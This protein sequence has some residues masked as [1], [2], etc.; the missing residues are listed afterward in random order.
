MCQ[1]YTARKANMSMFSRND[2]STLNAP[3]EQYRKLISKILHEGETLVN[4]R[5]GV[6]VF[7]HV[8]IP[9]VFT[10]DLG[11]GFPVFQNRKYSPYI[12][13]AETAWQ[14]SGVQNLDLINKY[15]PK[16]W[17][18]FADEDNLI[19][20]AQGYKWRY[21]FLRNQIELLIEQLKY[22]PTNRQLIVASWDPHIDGLG[23]TKPY[24]DCLPFMQ[25]LPSKTK[26]NLSVYS[27]SADMILGFPYDVF[28]YTFILYAVCNQA[29][30]TPGNL[31]IILNN[32]H[33][34][35]LPDHMEVAE[36]L[37]YRHNI[38][39]SILFVYPMYDV[40]D[41][42]RI[43]HEYILWVKKHMSI[44]HTYA[45]KVELVK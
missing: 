44:S 31:S 41:I 34:Y 36:N 9:Q 26:L 6:K 27:R 13:A 45:P 7:Q 3:T 40:R 5:T 32:M 12:S 43:P 38:E 33:V 29:G 20:N 21:G 42:M 35:D 8:T 17:S 18:K 2:M 15:A 23:S 11:S 19:R 30:Y 10:L 4:K 16:L 37:I 22:N 14:F 24:T 39:H 1:T 25:F 28:N